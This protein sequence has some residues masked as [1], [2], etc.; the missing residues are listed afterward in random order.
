MRNRVLAF[1]IVVCTLLSFLVFGTAKAPVQAQSSKIVCDSTLATLIYVAAHDYGY[2]STVDL[3]KFETGQFGPL[4]QSMMAMGSMKATEA[5][6]M[7]GT[8][9]ASM[10][11]GTK[12]SGMMMEGTKDAMGAKMVDLKPGIVKGENEACTKL[13]AEV[14]GYLFTK[15]SAGMKK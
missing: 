2:H 15:F 7:E 9:E 1:G 11:E 6:M 13:R 3:T 10:M 14:E 12:E 4:F 8:K 5:A